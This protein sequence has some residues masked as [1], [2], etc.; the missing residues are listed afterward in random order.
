MFHSVPRRFTC[1]IGVRTSRLQSKRLFRQAVQEEGTGSSPWLGR[2]TGLLLSTLHRAAVLVGDTA[3]CG[4]N[5][6]GLLSIFMD[7][8][9]FLTGQRLRR[10]CKIGE[11]Y[12]NLYSERA[13]WTL[14]GSMWR[15]FQSKHPPTGRLIAALAGIFMWENEKI[16]DEEMHRC[17]L[18][19]Q[20]LEVVKRQNNKVATGHMEPGWEV[21]MEKKDF[22]VWKRPIPDSH[23]YEYRVLGSY[24]DITPRQFFNVQLDTE[25]RKKWDALVIKLE[26]VD[27]DANTGSEVVHWATHFPYPMY[28]RDY[29]YVRRYDVDLE[30]NLMILVSRA[31]QHPRVPESQDFVRVHTY[32]SKMVIRPHT[33][34]DENGFDYLLTY[35]D[36]P[37]TAFPRYCVSWMVSS[38]MPDFLEKL[39]TAALKARN[40]EVGVYDY[41]SVIKSSDTGRQQSQERLAT[42]KSH[43]GGP[44]QMF[45]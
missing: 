38:G 37:Q 27:R 20:A 30:N 3:R 21:V 12:S 8:C 19:L 4:Q 42:E 39:H 1:E 16:Q 9:S 36:D 45:A 33:S 43:T 6:K 31:V 10:A 14:A 34:F 18:E 40:L 2:V 35:S 7:H 29:V 25:Y 13:R 23:L 5:R 22:R 28:S 32:K 17:G 44:G 26:V 11:L 41:A 15:R 24:S